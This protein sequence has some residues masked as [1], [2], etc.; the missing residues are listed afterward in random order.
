MS[1]SRKFE[2]RSAKSD[3]PGSRESP[4]NDSLL[5]RVPI[6]ISITADVWP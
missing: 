5:L 4:K 6:G 3:E 1:L 2:I